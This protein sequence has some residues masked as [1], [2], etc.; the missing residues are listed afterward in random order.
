MAKSALIE[1]LMAGQRFRQNREDRERQES[2][3][4]RT[5][6]LAEQK[7]DISKRQEERAAARFT[8]KTNM[9]NML[10]T[11]NRVKGKSNQDQLDILEQ[12]I[13]EKGAQGINVQDSMDAFNEPDYAKRQKMFDDVEDLSERLGY[14]EP[15]DITA[16]KFQVQQEQFQQQQA[17][18]KEKLVAKQEQFQQ[19]QAFEKE[20][21]VAKQEQSEKQQTFKA[22]QAAEKQTQF[23][24]EQD[25]KERKF[26][27]A[28][29]QFKQQQ[30]LRVKAQKTQESQFKKQQKLREQ[31]FN[32]QEDKSDTAKKQFREQQDLRLKAQKEKER[33]FELEQI[34]KEKQYQLKLRKEKTGLELNQT[35]RS[36]YL[37]ENKNSRSLIRQYNALEDDYTADPEVLNVWN[38]YGSN[39]D[40][41]QEKYLKTNQGPKARAELARVKTFISSTQYLFN[42]AMALDGG[43][44]ITDNEAVRYKKALLHGDM[45][46]TE[47]KAMLKRLRGVLQK[48]TED[49]IAVLKAGKFPEAPLLSKTQQAENRAAARVN[50]NS[51]IDKMR[52]E[53][54]SV[55]EIQS[56]LI[57]NNLLKPK[58]GS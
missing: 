50:V 48:A 21:L 33:Q 4:E 40:A 5:Q 37:K 42:K 28:Q 8:D 17:F 35:D 22:E 10:K 45:S 57:E 23:K 20:K 47:Y 38:K 55:E 52:G 44:Q 31:Q 14:S 16:E 32:L 54:K 7:F 18:E 36:A 1:G 51:I 19:Q 39:V 15:R 53:N 2:Q 6:G 9:R 34:Y 56:Y 24:I 46:P 3:F 11:I 26:G 49:N 27:S 58:G 12:E 13:V 30:G 29:K 25:L 41:W 43:K